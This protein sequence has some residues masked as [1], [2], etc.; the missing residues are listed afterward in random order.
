[1][2]LRTLVG[3]CLIVS[4]PVVMWTQSHECSARSTQQTKLMGEDHSI[5][6]KRQIERRGVGENTKVTLRDK[7]ELKGFISRID[8]ESFQLTDKKSGRE[9]TISFAEVKRV[10]NPGMSRGAKIGSLAGVAGGVIV[11]GILISLWHS[12]E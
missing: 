8:P 6:V 2:K 11:A 3:W 12:G 1:M 4:L 10:R 7:T 5:D 9:T